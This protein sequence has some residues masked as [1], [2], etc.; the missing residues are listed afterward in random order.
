[1]IA[2]E[3]GEVARVEDAADRV[4]DLAAAILS[5]PDEQREVVLRLI[6]F[7]AQLRNSHK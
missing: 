6:D 3:A 7:L 1:M 4:G 5:L 2:T